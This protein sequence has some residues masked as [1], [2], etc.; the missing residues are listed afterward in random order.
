MFEN[1]KAMNKLQLFLENYCS[2]KGLGQ[3]GSLAVW[4]TRPNFDTVDR[5]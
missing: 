1:V 5:E 2:I 3:S 4:Q